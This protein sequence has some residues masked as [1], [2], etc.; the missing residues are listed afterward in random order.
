[1]QKDGFQVHALAPEDA[2]SDHIIALG[3]IYHPVKMNNTGSNPVQDLL[4]MHRLY[5]LYQKISPDLVLHYTIKPNIYGSLVARLL[6]IPTICTV[7]G[8]GTVFLTS[9][10][11]NRIAWQLYKLAF[12]FPVKV[13]FQNQSD[14][15][16]FKDRGLLT[17]NNYQVIPGSGIDI[18]RFMLSQESNNTSPLVFLMM[19][20]LIEE[21][22]VLDF[23]EASKILRQQG[24]PVICQLLG[25]PDPA[26]KRSIKNGQLADAPIEY[27]GETDDV[28]PYIRK[29]HVF[30]L[31][32]YREGLS[33]ALLE[34]AAMGKPIITT[35][36][37]GC[38]EVVKDQINGL[39]CKP[40]DPQDLAKKMHQ[41]YFL[42]HDKRIAMGM[43]GR[44]LVINQFSETRVIDIYLAV[45]RKLIKLKS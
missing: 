42:D 21:K 19:A 10:G 18:N 40:A 24:I 34:A 27:L 37:P 28:R 31:P 44:Q 23:L 43:A 2:Y 25:A 5:K 16:E 33:R 7:S 39:L 22:G 3:C 15:S 8:L 45:I 41:M 32:S 12:R 14:L 6:N 9:S 1:M 17:R 11:S 29:S 13:F 20:R 36:V 35:D 30:V 4:L 26:H 38:R